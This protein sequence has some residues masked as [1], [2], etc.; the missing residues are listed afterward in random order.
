M[1][2]II[3][4]IGKNYEANKKIFR[5]EIEIVGFIDNNKEKQGK[6]LDGIKIYSPKEINDLD[7]ECIFILCKRYAEVRKQ[8]MQ[9]DVQDDIVV[10]DVTQ[11]EILCELPKAVYY[12]Y[13]VH[14]R[15]AKK[16]LVFSPALISTG[17]QNVLYVFLSIL[18]KQNYDI[19]VVSK[20]DGAL[21]ERLEQIK[22]SVVITADF[23]SCNPEIAELVDWADVILVNTL[24]LSYVVEGV[25][26]CKKTILW[27]LHESA[28]LSYVDIPSLKRNLLTKNVCT[29]AVSEVV[30]KYLEGKSGLFNKI[31]LLP[32]GIPEYD[33]KVECADAV[34]NKVIFAIIG[35][36]G[37]I[38]G[39]DIFIDAISC[40]PP[41]YLNS[42]EFWIVGGGTLADD[43]VQ[44]ASLIDSI[45]ILGEIDNKKMPE[46]YEKLD[47][48]VCCSREESM[49]VTVIEGFMNEKTV[50]VSENA[51]VA[52]FIDNG[53]NGFVFKNEDVKGLCERIKWV[54]DNRD[55]SIIIGK[56]SRKIYDKYFSI[57][58]FEERILKVM[59]AE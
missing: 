10:Y 33:A 51:G 47:V 17:A 56:E 8:L 40:L 49:S 22:V 52:A 45:K 39:Q 59:E 53:N 23:R 44:K 58:V 11:I 14:K 27:W 20:A 12:D 31:K 38:K 37:H 6:E 46:L 48:V 24:W 57:P 43:L 34:K 13:S 42:A 9:L 29:Y 28:A 35:G 2:T 5:K 4:G 16:L 30:K 19:T 1:K 36:M 18:M 21:R 54:I 3:W 41:Q 50:I 26:T 7:F 55:M 32:F 15:N 25:S